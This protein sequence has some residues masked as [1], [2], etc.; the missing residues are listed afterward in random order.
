[1]TTSAGAGFR[2]IDPLTI[3]I[4]AIDLD[5]GIDSNVTRAARIAFASKANQNGCDSLGRCGQ[6]SNDGSCVSG[7]NG[8]LVGHGLGDRISDYDSSLGSSLDCEKPT[9]KHVL[10]S[11]ELF[12]TSFTATE[13]CVISGTLNIAQVKSDPA[14][15]SR[16]DH[17]TTVTSTIQVSRNISQ[18]EYQTYVS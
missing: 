4:A 9:V 6:S 11:A 18:Y 10:A 16:I 8:L 2:D 7:D 1:M 13:L 15:I 14:G 3:T 12:V 5:K 17:I